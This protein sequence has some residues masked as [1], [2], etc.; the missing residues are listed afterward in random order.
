MSVEKKSVH[1]ICIKFYATKFKA[2]C[3]EIILSPDEVKILDPTVPPSEQG[4]ENCCHENWQ[5]YE[6]IGVVKLQIEKLLRRL[7]RIE[8]GTLESDCEQRYG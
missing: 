3:Q 2:Y 6:H 4:Y 8:Q 1:N 7:A 5:E